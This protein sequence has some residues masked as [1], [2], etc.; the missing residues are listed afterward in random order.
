LLRSADVFA[1]RALLPLR[2]RGRLRRRA[3]ERSG[4]TQ[5]V[6]QQEA[7]DDLVAVERCFEL[8]GRSRGEARLGDESLEA[9][10]VEVEDGADRFFDVRPRVG[11]GS[12][13]RALEETRD[14]SIVRLDCRSLDANGRRFL[15]S[16]Q[17]ARL[18][19]QNFEGGGAGQEARRRGMLRWRANTRTYRLRQY[20]RSPQ[21]RHLGVCGGCWPRWALSLA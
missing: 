17:H 20:A 6:E 18:L 15:V 8:D 14:P 5:A 19:S 7:H 11:A 4:G 3:L 9:V 21:V 12:E 16:S 2:I 13:L 1:D 10:A